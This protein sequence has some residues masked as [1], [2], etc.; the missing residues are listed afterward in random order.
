M[1]TTRDASQRVSLIRNALVLGAIVLVIG[2]L[3]S[4]YI[5]LVTAHT[6]APPALRV[7]DFLWTA[8]RW[9]RS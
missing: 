3:T 7:S 6:I 2:L 8:Y 1:T 4:F 9:L 5:S